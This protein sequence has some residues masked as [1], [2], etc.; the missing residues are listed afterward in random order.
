MELVV[1]L[2]GRVRLVYDETLSLE[3]LGRCSIRRAS[4]VEP[5]GDGY[6]RADLAAVGG[7]VLGPF[8][9]RSAALAAE[10]AWL[11]DHWL[12]AGGI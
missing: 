4:R 10:L 3:G 11:R 1:A 5:D 9:R 7:P 2:G 6:W 12:E 8:T